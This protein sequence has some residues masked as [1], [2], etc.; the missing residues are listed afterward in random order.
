MAAP[1]A[2]QKITALDFSGGASVADVT[3]ETNFNSTTYTLGTTTVGVTFVA[4]TS[5]A[6]LI[7]FGGRIS[8][9]SSTAVRILMAAEV[10]AGAVIGAGTVVSGAGDVG[11]LECGQI[12]TVRLGASKTRDVTGLTPGSTYNVS[13]WFKNA[14]A[15]ASAG[16]I[17]SRDIYVAPMFE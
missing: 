15:V 5:G 14:V 11:A 8:L 4:P 10:R 2:G 9:N 16:S 17:F 6:V 12:A 7:T 1:L 13:L 3:A